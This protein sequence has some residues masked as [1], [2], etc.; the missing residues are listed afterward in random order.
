MVSQLLFGEC[1]EALNEKNNF[2]HIKN[3]RDSYSGWA[4]KKMLTEIS[5]AG[6]LL[7]QQ[8]PFFMLCVPVAEVFSLSEQTIYHL[9]AGSCMPDYDPATGKFG[10]GERR[11]QVHPDLVSHLPEDANKEGVAPIASQFLNTPYLW[12]G[13]TIMGMDCSG[14]AQVVFSLCGIFL[15]R[16]ANQQA[17]MGIPVPFEEAGSGDLLFFEKNG[18][19]THVGI[20]LGEGRVLHASGKVKI[21]KVDEHGIL[22]DD[23]FS[24][25]HIFSGARRYF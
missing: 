5:K 4:D 7:L 21:N 12:G 22:S 10:V 6:Y 14:L 20:Y 18:K 19:I 25:T 11:F 23:E 1:C 15:P 24:Y 8:S 9:P 2:V 16:D 3:A 17:G 13:K